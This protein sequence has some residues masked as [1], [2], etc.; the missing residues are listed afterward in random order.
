MYIELHCIPVVLAVG[1]PAVDWIQQTLQALHMHM[2]GLPAA[3][4]AGLACMKPYAFIHK[5]DCDKCSQLTQGSLMHIAY[6]VA[7]CDCPCITTTGR[8]EIVR[9]Q[10]GQQSAQGMLCHWLGH[11]HDGKLGLSRQAVC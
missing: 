10:G 6:T 2:W 3:V 9:N 4:A 5:H 8:A 1:R 11:V 7:G